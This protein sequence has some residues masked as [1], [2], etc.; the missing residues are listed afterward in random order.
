MYEEKALVEDFRC[1]A[2]GGF[3]IALDLWEL[4]ILPSLMYNAC[5]WVGMGREAE[6]QLENLQCMYIR[7][8]MGGLPQSCP[9]VA[10]RSETGLLAMKLRVWK[11]KVMFVL[12]LRKLEVTSLAKQV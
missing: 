3:L 9:K 6:E 4:A 1:Q 12:H 2:I 8:L 11:E 7:L 5:T 10:L